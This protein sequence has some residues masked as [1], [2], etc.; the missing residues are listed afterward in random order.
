MKKETLLLI[1]TKSFYGLVTEHL[2]FTLVKVIQLLLIYLRIK[3]TKYTLDVL[4]HGL[5]LSFSPLLF[6][7]TLSLLSLLSH[8]DSFQL[9]EALQALLP[10]NFFTFYFCSW[11]V[12]PS[13]FPQLTPNLSSHLSSAFFFPGNIFPGKYSQIFYLSQ[14]PLLCSLI[15][16]W[17]SL[18]IIF[19]IVIISKFSV[20]IWLTYGWRS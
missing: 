15:D 12:L 5:T 19:S 13:A 7:T 17:T 2:P 1:Y 16:P 20:M 18:L 3:Y 4:T 9:H 10:H 11:S 8:P 14:I 6:Y